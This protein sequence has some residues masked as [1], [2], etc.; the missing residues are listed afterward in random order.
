M[1]DP[2][3]ME[4]GHQKSLRSYS[5]GRNRFMT[6]ILQGWIL[7]VWTLAAKLPNSYLN[8]AVDFG[9]GF[10]SFFPRKRARK[11]PQKNPSQ[12]SPDIFGEKFP[13]GFCRSLF[14]TDLFSCVLFSFLPL[15]WPPLFLPFSR[16]LFTLFSP[17][18]SA[19]FCRAKGKAQ[20]L[21]RGRLRMDLSKQFGKEIPSRNLRKKRSV[22]NS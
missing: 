5:V 11:H 17:S 16:H 1:C 7:A 21:E 9:V 4:I 20:S 3:R 2:D 12:S 6:T 8:F 14:L 13:S 19:L 22:D 10:C 15:C 18:K